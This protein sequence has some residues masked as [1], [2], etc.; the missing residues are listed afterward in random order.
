MKS[1]GYTIKDLE[2]LSGIKA[3]TIR[4][5][6][7]RYNLLIPSRTET[8]IRFYTDKDLKRILNISML[9]RNGYKISKV[10]KFEE[11]EIKNS[12]LKITENKNSETDYIE[13]FLRYM[14]EFDQVNFIKLTE[15]MITR[16]GFEEAVFKVFFKL[17]ER[18]GTFW[19]VGTIFPAQEHFVTN[20]FRQKLISEIDKFEVSNK[21]NAS[22]LFFL[23]EDELHEIGLLFY[24]YL[25]KKYGY[26]VI[27]LGQFV[28]FKD[29]VS[30]AKNVEIDFVFTAFVNSFPKENLEKYLI[31]L[32]D[33]FQ[34]Q[35][36]FVTGWQIQTQMPDLPRNVKVVKDHKDFIKFLR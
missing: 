32:K 23:P 18:I 36:V 1:E 9:V 24:S 16:F 33:V 35:K 34:K 20:L 3:H 14:L 30:M 28:P 11:T 2:V 22:I 8:N 7:K 6:E 31:D 19:Q 27:Y 12:V 21:K 10:A 15:E 17:F 4:I 5:W 29:L 13:Q 26:N 25:A